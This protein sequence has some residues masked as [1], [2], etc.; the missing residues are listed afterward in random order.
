M[1][2]VGHHGFGSVIEAKAAAQADFERRV[3]ECVVTKPVDCALSEINELLGAGQGD[4]EG[5]QILPDF[6][7]DTTV[8]ARV[9]EGTA[10]GV[11]VK[12]KSAEPH[13][14]PIYASPAP[15][16]DLKA[17][18]E[19][20]REALKFYA[21]VHKYPSPLTGGMGDLWSDC[22]RIARAA[23]NLSEPQT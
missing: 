21:D 20:L 1:Q 18:N 14:M 17:E 15:A 4:D 12:F 2:H 16:A 19:R 5:T 3:S 10:E 8:L 6:D 23:L 13:I 22:G 7:E 11:C 9:V